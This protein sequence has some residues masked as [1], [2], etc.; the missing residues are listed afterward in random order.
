MGLFSEA[1]YTLYFKKMPS[2]HLSARLELTLL[3]KA[4]LLLISLLHGL[5]LK[6]YIFF[7]AAY[8]LKAYYFKLLMFDVLVKFR[9]S[10]L[11]FL[12]FFNYLMIRCDKVNIFITFI[13]LIIWLYYQ[14]TKH[15][16][17][18]QALAVRL[19][20]KYSLKVSCHISFPPLSLHML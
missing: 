1:F 3:W 17:N 20:M 14:S 9:L 13:G 16:V 7:Q 12:G 5:L 4:Y 18:L 11:I 15:W 6:L 8:I 10:F 19:H 2:A